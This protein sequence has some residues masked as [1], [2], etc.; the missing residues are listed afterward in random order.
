METAEYTT[1]VDES[2]VEP[3]LRLVRDYCR[4]RRDTRELS[5][6]AFLRFGVLRVMGQC[7]SGRDFLQAQ[8]DGGVALARSTWFDALHSRRRGTMVAEVATRSYEVFSRFL[9]DRDWLG[10]FPE[11]RGRA[12]WAI[13]GHHIAHACH[14]AH[15]AKNG[16]V[17][18]GQLYGLCL[19]SG[20]MRALVPF[21]GDGARHHEFPVFK[22]NW[23][24]WLRQDRGEQMPIAVLDPA[25]IDVLYW[26]EQRRLR[27]AV[28]ITREKAN[29]KPTCISGYAY[30]PNDPVNRGVE[31]DEMAGYTYAYLRRIVFRDPATGERYVFI[32]TELS[33]RPGLIA[34]LYFLRW[35]IEKVYD[36]YKNKFHQQKAW[37]NGT[38]ANLAQ[39]HLTAL[40]HN[41]LTLLLVTLETAGITEQKIVRRNAKRAAGAPASQRVPTQEM[42][43]HAC[44]LTCQFIRAVRHCLEYKIPWR[45]ALPVF[46]RRLD[47]YL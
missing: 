25:Y 7:D 12:V 40:T 33:L 41:L 27:R 32:T 14:A 43:R 17:S 47:A 35:K 30:D 38:V 42:V 19:H 44:Q 45:A 1:T 46:Q 5:D 36:V 10:A 8:Q 23:T 37:A 9:E 3:A 20:L 6:E 15:D 4:N 22:E 31:A 26:S 24:R 13:D 2:F 28:M 11:L 29:M 39:A 34:L 21:Q 18:V 16:F